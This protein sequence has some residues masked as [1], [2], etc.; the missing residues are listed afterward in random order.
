MPLDGTN[1]P[2]ALHK[3]KRIIDIC[4]RIDKSEHK[5]KK[6]KQPTRIHCKRL[7]HAYDNG[8]GTMNASRII[9]V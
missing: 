1:T 9:N 4:K 7:E 5:K 8:N 2:R 3:T 6:K